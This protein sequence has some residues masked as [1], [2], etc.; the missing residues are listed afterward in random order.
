MGDRRNHRH[1]F[2]QENG[3]L[4]IEYKEQEFSH[5]MRGLGY[6]CRNSSGIMFLSND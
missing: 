3:L 6:L 2:I 1:D 5:I 4:E